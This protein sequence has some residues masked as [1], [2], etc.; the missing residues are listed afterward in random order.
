MIPKSPKAAVSLILC[1]LL[2]SACSLRP[3]EHA[4]PKDPAAETVSTPAETDPEPDDPGPAETEKPETEAFETVSPETEKPETEP[5]ETEAPETEPAETTAPE[6]EAPETENPETQAP[7]TE[8]AETEAPLPPAPGDGGSVDGDEWRDGGL[9][10]RFVLPGEDWRYENGPAPEE[11]SE[12]NRYV[13]RAGSEAGSTVLFMERRIPLPEDGGE[14]VTLEEYVGILT[15]S[16]LESGGE[17][18]AVTAGA[19]GEANLAG[20]TWTKTE[21]TLT[22]PGDAESR[23]LWFAREEGG[24]FLTLAVTASPA[25]WLDA[26]GIL[27]M[28]TA[29]DDPVPEKPV[30][31]GDPVPPAE[32][33]WGSDSLEGNVYRN[34]FA[35]ISVTAAQGWRYLTEWELADRNGYF[36]PDR[37]SIGET[38]DRESAR[39]VMRLQNEAGAS[40]ELSFIRSGVF[41]EEGWEQYAAY[42]TDSLLRSGEKAGFAMSATEGEWAVMA[43]ANWFVRIVTYSAGGYPV[44]QRMLLWRPVEGELAELTL[45]NGVWTD[46]PLSDM[47]GMVGTAE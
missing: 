26:D 45:D 2:L 21:F 17:D 34:T 46:I 35:G 1:A 13:L 23:S 3:A 6:T 9:N 15:E 41:G 30:R 43:G 37:E 25:D 19:P 29:A 8:P 28:L 40:V 33:V 12:E 38:A 47:L 10:L 18:V 44:G 32:F 14:R 16:M 5:R 4:G 39:C 24:W 42:L 20:K 27:T 7:E 11:E 36:V 31:P 22:W